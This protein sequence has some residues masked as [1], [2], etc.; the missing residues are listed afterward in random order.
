M[1]LGWNEIRQRATQ[2]ARDWSQTSREAADAKPFWEAFLDVFGVPRRSVATFEEPVRKLDGRY[3]YIDLFWKGKLLVEHKSRGKSLERA[4]AQAFDY[5]QALTSEGRTDEMPRYVVVSDFDRM[6][7]HDLE[8]PENSIE[9]A[10]ADLP[11]HIRAFGFIPGYDVR[12]TAPDDPAN[13]RAAEIMGRLHDAL[14]G[15]GYSGHALERLLVRVLFCLFAEDTGLFDPGAFSEYLLTQT[16]P[17]GSDLGLHLGKI[18]QVLD[19]PVEK[20]SSLLDERLMTLPYVNGGLF[21]ETLLMPDCDSKMREALIR[22]TQFDWSRISPAIFGALFQSVMDPVAR[23]KIGAHYT[24]EG[25]ILKVIGPL[26][27]DDLRA[28]FAAIRHDRRRLETFHQKL[29][30]LTFLDPACGCGNFLVVTYRELRLLELQVLEVLHADT[31]VTD[32]SLLARVEV[33]QFYGFEIDEWPGRIAETA[34]WL[35]DHQMN[36]MFGE[37]FGRYFNRLPLRKSPTIVCVNALQVN[38]R[39]YLNPVDCSYILGNPPFIGKQHQTAEQ[40]SE[41]DLLFKGVKGAGVIDYVAGWYVK[42][43]AFI[44]GTSIRVGF[45]STN[46]IC[47]GEQVGVLWQTLFAAGVKILFAYPTFSWESEARGKAHVHVVIIGFGCLDLP[48]KQIFT[49]DGKQTSVEKV[50]NISPYLVEGP[51]IVILPRTKPISPVPEIVFGS[52]PNDGGHFLLDREQK[53]ALVAADPAAAA[54]IRPFRGAQ[55]FINR[56]ERWCL[57]LENIRPDDLRTMPDVLARVQ[58]VRDYRAASPRETTRQLGLTPTLFGEIRQPD[59]RY[60]AIPATSS[61]RRTYLPIDFL[62]SQIIA[63]NAL[64]IVPDAECWHFGVLT[65]AMHNAWMR[66]VCGRLESRYRYSNK[67]VYNNFPW[68]PFEQ[69]VEPVEDAGGIAVSEAAARSYWTSYHEPGDDGTPPKPPRLVGDAKKIAAVEAAAQAVLDV[70]AA[71]PTSTLA[72]LYDPLLMPP[73]LVKAHAT[74]DRA[75][76]RCYRSAPFAND[77]QRVEFLFGLC[78]KLSTPLLPSEKPRRKKSV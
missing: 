16:R 25:N 24:S 62:S 70:R 32:I 2:F 36:L 20:R 75:V 73:D 56:E 6:A 67:L 64:L 76:D 48:A 4:H 21:A 55:E 46:S 72:D 11:R 18:F 51:D 58:A 63:G 33:D 29:G 43:A 1:R 74:L 10:V 77:R 54:W 5:L 41:L 45:V 19:T 68:P 66:Q 15:S 13:L 7:L 3:G 22:C 8:N 57:W 71:Y 42:A 34:M 39:D 59:G 47:Q 26:F 30:K 49:G 12:V 44:A 60:L 31:L 65:S 14:A 35:M 50:R 23:R 9:F 69:A 40:K 53:E 61:E 28:E 27:L 52:M 17:D 78:E 38:W 37:R